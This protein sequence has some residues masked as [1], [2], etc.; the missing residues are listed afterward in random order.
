[1]NP[2]PHTTDEA[3]S[4][5]LLTARK[6]RIAAP[7]YMPAPGTF[8]G[9]RRRVI[10]APNLLRRL[11]FRQT[12]SFL[13]PGNARRLLEVGCGQGWMSAEAARAGFRVIG[14]D[15]FRDSDWSTWTGCGACFVQA[16]G[17]RLPFPDHVFD[18]I[19]LLS[20]LP[21]VPK[22]E[23]I[24]RECARVLSLSPGSRLVLSAPGPLPRLARHMPEEELRSRLRHLFHADGP[25][26]FTLDEIGRLLEGNGLKIARAA[27]TPGALTSAIWQDAIRR[28]MVSG[29]EP[30]LKGMFFKYYPFLW[31]DRGSGESRAR[32]PW[33][34]EWLIAAEPLTS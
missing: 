31:W 14:S 24:L 7:G 26:W 12:L 32:A 16:D 33:G 10:G 22:A 28:G 25:M 20:V 30:S 1:M 19:L 13:G 15:P 3:T 6:R 9:I 2:K 29:R 17:G 27:Q 21:V 18:C 4:G 5:P 23:P 34:G 11:Q 8:R